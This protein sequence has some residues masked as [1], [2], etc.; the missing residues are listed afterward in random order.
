[1][2]GYHIAQVNIARMRGPLDSA[3]MAGFPRGSMKSMRLPIEPRG[4][5]GG[6][7]LLTAMPL[8]FGPMTTI[9]FSSTC[10]FGKALTRSEIMSTGAPTANC[11]ASGRSGSKNSPGPLSRCGGCRPA[12][13]PVS[14][15]RRNDWRTSRHTGRPSSRLLSRPFFSRTKVFSGRLTGH[16]SSPVRRLDEAGPGSF[17][18]AKKKFRPR[19]RIL[20]F[21]GRHEPRGPRSNRSG[22]LKGMRGGWPSAISG[23]PEGSRV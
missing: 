7:R 6:S 14:T 10:R 4:L 9:A 11:F 16:P 2:T 8:T 13:S 17:T 12:T 18:A 21:R 15:R 20:L 22:T 23:L 1:M 5:S 19:L 3:R